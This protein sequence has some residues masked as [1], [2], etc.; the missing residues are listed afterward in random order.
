MYVNFPQ[1]MYIVLQVLL[2]VSGG[3]I[4]VLNSRGR[5]DVSGPDCPNC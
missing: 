3:K 1:H 4:H 5:A 2:I